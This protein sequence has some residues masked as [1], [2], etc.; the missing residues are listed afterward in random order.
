MSLP[1]ISSLKALALES[2]GTKVLEKQKL[3]DDKHN[4]ELIE[5]INKQTNSFNNLKNVNSQEMMIMFKGFM[6]IMKNMQQVNLNNSNYTTLNNSSSVVNS[7]SASNNNPNSNST[8]SSIN[9][10]S[11]QALYC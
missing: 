9:N 5:A 11:L 6:E 1:D 7:S 2:A 3:L 8:A 10:M 4:E